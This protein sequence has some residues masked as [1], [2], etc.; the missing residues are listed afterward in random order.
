MVRSQ[1][2]KGLLYTV[3]FVECPVHPDSIT[4]RS[5]LHAL[6]ILATA[7]RV[8]L[9]PPEFDFTVHLHVII[10]RLF[11]TS[12]RRSRS[13][14][15]QSAPRRP[16]AAPA[17]ASRRWRG[18]GGC[19]C[20][21]TTGAWPPTTGEGFIYDTNATHTRQVGLGAADCLVAFQWLA[22]RL[23]IRPTDPTHIPQAHRHPCYGLCVWRL[24]LR[25][26]LLVSRA[27]R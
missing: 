15:A 16:P 4:A 27:L 11:S 18:W 12:P 19:R 24:P 14:A 3:L 21:L 10:P 8:L 2:C 26:R 20:W 9:R 23:A 17:A 6:A 7:C 25:V 22:F 5:Q 1:S 13:R